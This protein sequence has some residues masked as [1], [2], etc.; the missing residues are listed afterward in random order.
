MYSGYSFSEQLDGAVL[1]ARMM[2]FFRYLIVS[3]SGDV[4]FAP[5]GPAYSMTIDLTARYGPVYA[6]ALL[7]LHWLP[8]SGGDP[9]TGLGGQV[10]LIAPTGIDGFWLDIGYRPNLIF[11]E[12]QNLSYH[13]IQVGL[14]IEAGL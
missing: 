8:G 2:F 7:G 9:A 4:K 13:A 3:L 10:G 14:L 12:G 11:L 6:G 1:G 5:D